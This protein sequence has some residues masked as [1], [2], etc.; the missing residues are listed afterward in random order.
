M[1]IY[2]KLVFAMILWGGTFIS[3]RVL[4]Q[5]F[6]PFTIAFWRFAIASVFL[7]AVLIKDSKAFPSLNKYKVFKVV[8]L[9]L[10]GVFAYNY[11]FFSGLSSVEAGKAS[12]IIAINPTV[13]AF[14]ASVFMGEG[15]SFKKIVGIFT[16]LSGALVVITKGEVLNLNF[17]EF[18]YGEGYLLCAVL[19]WVG[20]TL[21]GKVA[22]KKLTALEATT[23]ACI[24]GTLMLAPFAYF[25]DGFELVA[26]AN[27]KQWWHLFY[28]GSLGTGLGFI[29][30]YE[31]IQ[32][33][34][35]SRAASFINLVPVAG[36]SIGAIALGEKINNSLL[37]GGILVLFGINLVNW[38]AQKTLPRH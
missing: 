2:I 4:S 33:I 18:G 12:V 26:K 35:A 28:L 6:H 24:C 38:S 14:I 11:F 10:S 9:G 29:W 20:Y 27:L 37:L 3:G 19:C 17:E 36:V 13:T 16:A 5:D 34:G 30:F 22:L 25:Y 7:S 31:G 23:L 21:I 15:A 1:K 32:Q 8:L